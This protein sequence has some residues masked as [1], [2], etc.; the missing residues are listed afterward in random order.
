V[1][2]RVR[3]S[4]SLALP[5]R[6]ADAWRAAA[7]APVVATLAKSRTTE[8][9]IV[10]LPDGRRAVR[11]C[12]TW[13]LRRDRA[14]G[15]LRTTIAARSPAR[16]EFDALVRL[17]ALPAG[18]FAPEPLGWLETRRSAVLCGC[19]LLLQE[20][21][22]ATDLARALAAAAPDTRSGLLAR[23]ADRLREMHDCGLADREMHPRNVLVTS[24]GDVLKVDCAKQR[25]RRTT[26]SSADRVRDLADLDVGVVRLCSAAERRAFLARY[27][28][29][30][31]PARALARLERQVAS[32]RARIDARES[33][34]LPL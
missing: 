7:S 16:R 14:K 20:V 30:Q 29:P 5:E 33:R 21:V 26:A 24:Q 2:I 31:T 18:P 13:P 32:R 28:G 23:L 25:V 1:G 27:L 19:M 10:T 6:G 4:E 9:A 12:W 17:R 8:T 34:R 3:L 11:K 15:A 22:G